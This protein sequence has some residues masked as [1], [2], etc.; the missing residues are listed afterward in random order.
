MKKLHR[1]QY[2]VLML[3]GFQGDVWALS[4]HVNDFDIVTYVSKP[5]A[6]DEENMIATTLSGSKYKLEDCAGNLQKQID[7][8][9]EDI[10]KE[11]TEDFKKEHKNVN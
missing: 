6:L 5:V 2:Q 7:Y 1:W 9:K 3:G 8:I 4:G 10:E 11:I